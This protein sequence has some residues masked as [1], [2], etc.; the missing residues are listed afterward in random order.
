MCH[1]GVKILAKLVKQKS[2]ID[3][4]NKEDSRD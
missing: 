2:E 3:G 1:T 4:E